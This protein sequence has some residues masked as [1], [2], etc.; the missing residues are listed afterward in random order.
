[1]AYNAFRHCEGSIDVD[2]FRSASRRIGTAVVGI[3]LIA[4]TAL[5]SFPATASAATVKEL[6]AKY[7]EM[8]AISNEKKAEYEKEADELEAL[9]AS[10]YKEGGDPSILE[11]LTQSESL[12]DFISRST[13]SNSIQEK[14][15][16]QVESVK[17]AKDEADKAAAD[18]KA[19]L[20]QKKAQRL[21]LENADKIHFA[22][23]TGG[24]WAKR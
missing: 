17:K 23:W 8:V 18:A 21:S 14:K 11:I 4:G 16:K 10:S 2:T 13:Y 22:Q 19:V 24:D 3:A 20:E 1:M 15:A 6:N 9:M 7:D 5:A 12:D